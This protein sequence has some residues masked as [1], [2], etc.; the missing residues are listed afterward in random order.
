[1]TSGHIPS[2]AREILDGV[3]HKHDIAVRHILGPER[4]RWAV[5]ARQEAMWALRT[6]IGRTG[7]ARWTLQRVAAFVG[8]RDHTT[9][10]HGVRAHQARL[11]CLNR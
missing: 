2:R 3:A 11:T 7:G 9:V 6:E 10:I 5:M 1:M 8:R 4:G